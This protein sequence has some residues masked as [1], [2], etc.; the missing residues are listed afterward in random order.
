MTLAARE[1]MLVLLSGFV[2]T[3]ALATVARLRISDLVHERPRTAEELA[4]ATGADPDAL[5]R[6]LRA[7]AS[8]GVFAHADGIV[9]QTDLSELLREEAPGSI[10]GHA[11]MFATVHYRAWTEAGRSLQTGEPAFEHVFGLQLFDWLAE[12]P[13]GSELFNRSMAASA[14]ARQ[15][16]L[17]A[18][19]WS[20]V[21]TIVDVGGGTGTM[22]TSLLAQE[23]HLRG[24]VFD[25]PHLR[26][27]T[28]ATIDATGVRGRCT[29]EG[30]SFFERVP[31]GADAYVLSQILHDWDDDDAARILEVCAAAARPESRL[32]LGEVV[33]VPGDEPDWGKFLD[34][35][36]LVLLGG[37]ER[38]ED[39]WRRLLDRRGFTFVASD[40]GALLIEAVPR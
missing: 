40:P 32:V 27:E 22:L 31:P 20:D 10:H 2:V 15:A 13:E 16:A 3:Q 14:R 5:G 33:L 23:P 8:L 38:S 9:H 30:G 36:M 25:L 11:E 6:V 4:V 7:L 21:E 28:E 24:V 12:H 18:R 35:H 37:R 17:L 34:L 19:D 29:F 26:D 1:R 39:E